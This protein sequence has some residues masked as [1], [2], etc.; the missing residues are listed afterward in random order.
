VR[1]WIDSL[2]GDPVLFVLDEMPGAN[3]IELTRREHER[4]EE[5]RA[6]GADL[7][8]AARRPRYAT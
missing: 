7:L 8:N 6:A 2:D 5:Y 3:R 1:D 4:I